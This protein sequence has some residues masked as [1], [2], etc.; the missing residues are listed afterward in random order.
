MVLHWFGAILSPD[1]RNKM[2]GIPEQYQYIVRDES[3]HVNF[4]IDVINQIRAENFFE[5]RVTEYRTRSSLK[6]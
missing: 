6:R 3:L 1:R 2:V 5:T 4:G